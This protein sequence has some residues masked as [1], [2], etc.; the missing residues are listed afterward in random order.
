MIAPKALCLMALVAN[1]SIAAAAVIPKLERRSAFP[2]ADNHT[3]DITGLKT[4]W[5]QSGEINTQ[6]PV[7][8]TN[9]RQSHAYAVQV[10]LVSTPNAYYDSFVYESIPRNGNGP[11]CSPG[12]TDLCDQD[13]DGI[14]IESDIGVTMAWTQFLYGEDVVVQVQR[15]NGS[16]LAASDIVIR[17]TTLN[18]TVTTSGNA[19]LVTVPYSANGTRFSIEFQDDLFEYHNGDEGE[20]SNYVQ[21]VNPNGQSYVSSYDSSMPIVGEEPLNALL[22][23]ASPMPSADMMPNDAANTLQVEPGLVSGLDST[24]K[25]IIHFGPG[26]YYMTGTDRA[27]LSSSVT[28]VYIEAGAYIKGAIEYSNS[29]SDLLA[30]GHGVLSGE[31]Y[32]YQANTEAGFADTK[33]DDNS[34]KMWRASNV[35]AGKSWTLYGLTTANPPFNSHDFY[36]NT[37]NFS[38]YASDYKQV[39]AFFYQ[40][41]G[42]EMYPGSQVHDIFY[43]SG[44]DT[45]KTYYSDVTVERVTVWKTSNAPVIQFGWQPRN[46]TNVMVDSVDVI[47]SRYSSN[48][49][50]APRSLIGS[51]AAYTDTSA[52]NTADSGTMIA[53][54]AVSNLR[55]E[56]ISPSIMGLNPLSNIANFTVDNIWVEEYSPPTTGIGMSFVNEFTDGNLN[57]APISIGDELQEHGITITDYYVGNEKITFGLDNW[58]ASSMG[59]LNVSATYWGKWTVN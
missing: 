3:A 24:D 13:D 52:T 58:A 43:H 48:N 15:Q 31:Q 19:A 20:D 34:L 10:G 28:W 11:I 45:I 49:I 38:V 35:A 21:N 8:N 40:T 46:I 9:V 12:S 44:D 39:G 37:D 53:N 47:H 56:G 42:L 6:T 55:S 14:T 32:V 7:Q 36:G 16:A 17:P 5:H 4:W 41:D 22:I 57:N 29:D 30:T 59:K 25:S 33:S 51:S 26:V 50:W 2:S 23:F 18:Y 54:Y 1:I 27:V